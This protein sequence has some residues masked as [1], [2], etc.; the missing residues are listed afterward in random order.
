MDIKKKETLRTTN[1]MCVRERERER[2]RDAK[3]NK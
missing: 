1:M 3:N 2:E